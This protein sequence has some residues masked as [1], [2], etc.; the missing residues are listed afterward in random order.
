MEN[1]S[2]GVDI[3]AERAAISKALASGEH[4]FEAMAVVGD[5]M[6]PIAPCGICRQNL[7]EFG[8]EIK[9]IMANLRGDASMATVS[10]LLPQAF[11]GRFLKKPD[12]GC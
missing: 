9:V 1:A 3:C 11:T 2:S 12:S 5:T 6:E 10:E 4:E 8:K 7:I